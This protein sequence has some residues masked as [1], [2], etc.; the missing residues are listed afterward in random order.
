MSDVFWDYFFKALVSIV[1]GYIAYRQNREQKKGAERT[2][3]I[4]EVVTGLGEVRSQARS[5]ARHLDIKED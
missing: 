4:D 5:I 1:L 2:V 3:K